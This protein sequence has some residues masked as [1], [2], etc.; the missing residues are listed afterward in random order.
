M[1][2]CG[3]TAWA[4]ALYAVPGHEEIWNRSRSQFPVIPG[5]AP[6]AS[7]VAGFGAA[8][9]LQPL[10]RPPALLVGVREAAV[11]GARAVQRRRGR[12]LHAFAALDVAGLIS[13]RLP[14]TMTPSTM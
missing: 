11:A 7:P 10:G 14:L 12:P 1:Y 13:G 8:A 5:A 2:G 6:F 3:V 9:D 4:T